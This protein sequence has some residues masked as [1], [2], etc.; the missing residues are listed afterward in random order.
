MSERSASS[1]P[2]SKKREGAG[3]GRA[4]P[5]AAPGEDLLVLDRRRRALAVAALL[6]DLHQRPLQ[7]PQLAHLL[8]EHVTGSGG[9]RVNHSATLTRDG[10]K[11]RL[12]RDLGGAT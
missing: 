12:R 8:G 3:A 1:S 10:A 7:A 5:P 4:A 2:S 11:A 6:E 9:D